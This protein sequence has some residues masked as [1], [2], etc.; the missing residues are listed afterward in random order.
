MCNSIFNVRLAF[1]RKQINKANSDKLR[2]SFVIN[3][4]ICQIE[5][6]MKIYIMLEIHKKCVIGLTT[7]VNRNVINTTVP[8]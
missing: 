6:I 5:Y 4:I 7:D 8:R 2:S 3:L 1:L